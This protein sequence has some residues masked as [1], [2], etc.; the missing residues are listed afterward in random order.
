M[1]QQGRLDLLSGTDLFL[2]ET[3]QRKLAEMRVELAVVNPLRWRSNLSSGSW[4]AGCSSLTRIPCL[5]AISR[6]SEAIRKE[7]L[8]RQGSAQSRYI[9][10]IRQLA[11]LRKLV[12][13]KASAV[14]VEA[15]EDALVAINATEPDV[16]AAAAFPR[17]ARVI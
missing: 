13:P 16:A 5:S 14:N 7:L 11:Q 15:S 3:V 9:D 12:S 10:A 8:K 2:R 4:Y 17:I 6:S 1:A